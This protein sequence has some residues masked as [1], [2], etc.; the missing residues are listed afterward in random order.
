MLIEGAAAMTLAAYRQV[1]AEFAGQNVVVILCGAN[2]SLATLRQ[3]LNA[4]ELGNPQCHYE[5]TTSSTSPPSWR[6]PA[7]ASEAL[8]GVRPVFGGQHPGGGT[9][10]ALLA[11]GNDTY[12]EVIAP[13]PD[14]T[15]PGSA[16]LL[17]PG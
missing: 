3:V 4:T 2:I 17:W 14:P 11:L 1:A 10:N 6:R 16:P 5:L 7:T 15:Q 8:L 12:L 9:H 13:D